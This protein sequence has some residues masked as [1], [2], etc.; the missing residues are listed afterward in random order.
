MS[1]HEARYLGLPVV[2]I[3]R[4]PAPESETAESVEAARAWIDAR[5]S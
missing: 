5:L 1:G 2:M 3:E 4:P